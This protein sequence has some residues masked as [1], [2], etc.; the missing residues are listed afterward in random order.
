[1]NFVKRLLVRILCR[2]PPPFD[3]IGLVQLP[4]G[5]HVHGRCC[6]CGKERVGKCALVKDQEG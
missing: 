6:R 5:F 4:S 3:Y 2:H 1:M